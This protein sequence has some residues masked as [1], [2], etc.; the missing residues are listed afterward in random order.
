MNTYINKR[1]I[2]NADPAAVAEAFRSELLRDESDNTAGR[3]II[4]AIAANDVN[5]LCNALTGWSVKDILVRAGVISDEDGVVVSDN[6]LDKL[7]CVA[8]HRVR[9]EGFNVEVYNTDY[10]FVA[11]HNV[12]V[13]EAYLREKFAEAAKAFMNTLDGQKAW[14]TTCHD[15][16]WGDFATEVPDEVLNRFGIYTKMPEA[17]HSLEAFLDLTVNQDE[18]LGFGPDEMTDD[19]R[20]A[21]LTEFANAIITS[22][23]D[24]IADKPEMFDVD[25]HD[26]E[27]LR[28]ETF[29]NYAR[30]VIRDDEVEP[31]PTMLDFQYKCAE[32]ILDIYRNRTI[33]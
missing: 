20:E 26:L 28:S 13:T 12:T 29:F 31:E 11:P 18:I 4:E 23:V 9:R 21:Y 2:E 17:T 27:Q 16:N 7:Y 10:Y 5:A 6:K 14:T 25:N 33:A 1:L 3:K 15:F 19:A 22:G 24:C 30:E 32:T 8:M